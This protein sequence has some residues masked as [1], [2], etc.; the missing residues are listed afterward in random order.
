MVTRAG[1]TVKAAT[2]VSVF[3]C[4]SEKDIVIIK[5]DLFAEGQKSGDN[6][7]I[8][9]SLKGVRCRVKREDTKRDSDCNFSIVSLLSLSEQ[10]ASVSGHVAYIY[11]IFQFR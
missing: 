4:D 9:K 7:R 8:L 1:K 2:C 11:N 3:H 5:K 10:L 6:T